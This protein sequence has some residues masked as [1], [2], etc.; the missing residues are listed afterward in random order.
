LAFEKSYFW[1]WISVSNNVTCDFVTNGN[2]GKVFKNN[3]TCDCVTNGNGG[4]FLKSHQSAPAD[5]KFVTSFKIA[6]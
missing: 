1:D 4:K 2:G 5:G 3:V 6:Q